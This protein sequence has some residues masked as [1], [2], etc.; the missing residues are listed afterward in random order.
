[1]VAVIAFPYMVRGQCVPP[2]VEFVN[3]PEKVCITDDPIP[4]VAY[5]EGGFFYIGGEAS[6]FIDPARLGVGQ[7]TLSYFLS[8]DPD[9][10]PA[11]YNRLLS[12][13]EEISV[14]P[15]ADTINCTSSVSALDIGLSGAEINYEWYGPDGF[16]SVAKNPT[17]DVIGEYFVIVSNGGCEASTMLTLSED[18]DTLTGIVVEDRLISCITDNATLEVRGDSL[19][20]AT[21]LWIGPSGFFSSEPNP[22]VS[23]P[24]Q[25]VVNISN[26]V[27]GC[28]SSLVAEVQAPEY[29]P[30]ELSSEGILTCKDSVVSLI[31]SSSTNSFTYEWETPAGEIVD[32]AELTVGIGGVY[33]AKVTDENGC[34]ATD[35][36]EVMVDRLPPQ[37][38]I[39]Y[40]TDSI[41]SCGKNEIG[42]A[43]VTDLPESLQDINWTNQ[44]RSLSTATDLS[45]REPGVYELEITNTDNGCKTK[46][47]KNVGIDTLSP[48]AMI[49]LELPICLEKEGQL[50]AVGSLTQGGANYNWQLIDNPVLSFPI[51]DYIG[52]SQAGVYVL[53]VADIQNGCIAYDTLEVAPAQTLPPNFSI[54]AIDPTC[55]GNNGYIRINGFDMDA[56]SIGFQ[57]EAPGTVDVLSGLEAGAFPVSIYQT[58]GCRFDTTIVLQPAPDFAVTLETE[59][60]TIALGQELFINAVFNVP[61]NQLSTVLWQKDEDVICTGCLSIAEQ[62]FR[63][64]VYQVKAITIDGCEAASKVTI[65]VTR[66]KDVYTGN[67]FSPNGDGANDFFRPFFGPSILSANNFSI[68]DRWGNLI[69]TLETLDVA[70][71]ETGWDGKI[72]DEEMPAGVYLYKVHV[73]Y[74]DGLTDIVSGDITL[75]R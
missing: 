73:N 57:G 47:L 39:I 11:I 32:G 2:E 16:F 33:T 18:R 69:Y 36:I 13:S 23:M 53:E 10:N 6:F 43:A 3:L 14:E 59:Q 67:I 20:G 54:E 35:N 70:Q 19:S 46:I 64:A 49:T 56:F 63:S 68:F 66:K 52:I 65:M 21:Y 34:V 27:N 26:P 4:L 31:A 51:S 17:T 5:P 45:V 44:N 50:S 71:N 1:M 8:F 58:K 72:N 28:I 25:Y 12:V 75:I 74:I 62:P 15:I 29:P 7:H 24:G 48:L 22:T 42:L 30:I 9:C 55:I 40:E 41:L 38:V 60:S 61:D 37:A